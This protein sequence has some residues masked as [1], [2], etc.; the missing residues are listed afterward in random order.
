MNIKQTIN[1]FTAI[2]G[3]LAL[4][5]AAPVFASEDGGNNDCGVDTAIIKCEGVDNSGDADSSGVLFLLKFAIQIMTAGVGIL[6]VG[7]IVYGSIL[8]TTAGGSSEQVKKAVGI[9][10]NVAIGI[11]AYGLMFALLNFLIPGGLFSDAP[12]GG[13]GNS[14]PTPPPQNGPVRFE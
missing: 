7:G 5:T 3:I 13:G 4:F 14:A 1:S 6:A 12:S 2:I 10:T 9:I 8:Y 11:L